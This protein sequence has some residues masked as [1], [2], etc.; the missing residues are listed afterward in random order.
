VSAVQGDVVGR[1][2]PDPF[3]LPPPRVAPARPRLLSYVGRWGRA[4]RWLRPETL[5]ILDVGCSFGYGSAAIAMGGPPGRV[6]VG[7]ERDQGHLDRARVRFPWLRVI[8]GDAN[9]L[10]VADDIA[11]AVLLLDVIEHIAEPER[12]ICQAA[13]VL[14]PGGLLIVTVPHRGILRWLDALNLY[15]S[16]RRRWPSLP[17]LEAATESEGGPHRH[18]T[19]DELAR[20]LGSRF[21]VE[22]VARTGLGTQEL[23]SIAM[24]AAGVGLRAQFLVRM[25]MPVHLIIGTLDDLL[26]TGRLAYNLAVRARLTKS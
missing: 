17:P 12:T 19:P 9:E 21:T 20:V 3:L 8:P 4:R 23:V 15:A 18:F 10:P 14:R 24:I 26:P 7:V 13:R 11:D 2:L 1:E 16:L 5:R 25:L 6:I 22:R